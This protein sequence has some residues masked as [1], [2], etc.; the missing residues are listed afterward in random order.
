MKIKKIDTT[1]FTTLKIQGSA[2]YYL[3]TKFINDILQGI[4]FA[5][6]RH[7]PYLC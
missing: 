4:E 7:L 5:K 6:D 3:K 1:N 2:K